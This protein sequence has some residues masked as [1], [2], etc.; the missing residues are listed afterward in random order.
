MI[1]LRTVALV[2]LVTIPHTAWATPIVI[3]EVLYDAPGP[4][5]PFAFTELVG[6][7]GISLDGWSLVGVNGS[8]GSPYRTIDL[9]GS[10]IP[11]DGI[12]VI[13][14]ASASIE[15]AAER[16][17][18]G[19]VDWQNGPDAI[20]LRNTLGEVPEIIDALQYGDAGEGNAGE[21]RPAPDIEPGFSLSRDP[22][23]TDTDDNATDFRAATP[24]PGRVEVV[25]IPEP[26]SLALVFLGL[27]A[28]LHRKKP[29]PQRGE[30]SGA[31][32]A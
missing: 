21:G 22:L 12:F 9:T 25:T 5:A 2:V 32:V 20:Q 15:L 6:P 1:L 18:I 14:T 24:T 16:D 4:D 11:L 31:V 7:P 8:T 28:V 30:R 27:A 19:N 29:L 26:P 10:S 23:S 3:Q 17:L 13:A